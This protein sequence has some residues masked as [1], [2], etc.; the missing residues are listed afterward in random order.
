MKALVVVSLIVNAV[1]V[2]VVVFQSSNAKF[3]AQATARNT[4]LMLNW[5]ERME[6][7]RRPMS[8]VKR[9]AP[10]GFFTWSKTF[11]DRWGVRFSEDEAGRVESVLCDGVT[12]AEAKRWNARQ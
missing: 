2:G 12:I 3:N 10:D 11:A 1:L 5:A 7:E 8:E 6:K 9:F 4:T